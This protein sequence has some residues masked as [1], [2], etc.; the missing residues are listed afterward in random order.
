MD[1]YIIL[2]NYLA[3]KDSHLW[4]YVQAIL[5]FLSVESLHLMLISVFYAKQV[6][7]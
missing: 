2:L 6:V 5:H 1:M 3:H 4:R 7:S